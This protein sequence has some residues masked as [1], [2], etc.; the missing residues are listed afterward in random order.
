MQKWMN[1][2]EYEGDFND[3]RIEGNGIAVNYFFCLYFK[4]YMSIYLIINTHMWMVHL[5]SE[6]RQILTKG[7]VHGKIGFF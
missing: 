1:G 7:G 2:N 3:D 5:I 6:K 4:N